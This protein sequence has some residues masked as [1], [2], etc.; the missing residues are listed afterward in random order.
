MASV[1]QEMG[2][3]HK[4]DLTSD[5]THLIVGSIDTPKYKY[6]AKERGDIKV[7]KVSWLDAV[8]DSWLQGEDTDIE[9]LEEEHR[10]PTFYDLQICVTGFDDA[11]IRQGLVDAVHNNGGFY[12]GDLTKKV[13]H[14]VAA[15][16]IGKKYDYAGQWGIKR[17][18]YEW[19]RDSLERKMA[20]DEACYSLD[21]ALEDRGK[22][23]IT[24]SP[25][26]YKDQGKRLHNEDPSEQLIDDGRRKLRRTASMKLGSQSGNLWADMGQEDRVPRPKRELLTSDPTGP[27]DLPQS[28]IFDEPNLAE[29][30]QASSAQSRASVSRDPPAGHFLDPGPEG[31]NH[32]VV[33]GF[34][35]KK[36][37]YAV[38]NCVVFID[39]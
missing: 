12:H 2:A 23:A 4:L 30:E 27:V 34:E 32:Y 33:F 15:A 6:V 36:V 37:T 11:D 16:G 18:A 8:R 22:G 38:I 1:A 31:N 3:S 26:A 35:E 20:L 14:L 39:S 17:V 10:L 9:A 19:V 28:Y 24:Y 13:T 5:V 25:A 29:G 7:L 21:R